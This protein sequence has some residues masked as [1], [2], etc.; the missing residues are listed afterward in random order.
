MEIDS[1]FIYFP[2]WVEFKLKFHHVERE[3]ERVSSFPTQQRNS[4]LIEA[5]PPL[6]FHLEPLPRG[7]DTMTKSRNMKDKGIS[8][9]EL[10]KWKKLSLIDRIDSTEQNENFSFISSALRDSGESCHQNNDGNYEDWLETTT[11]RWRVVEATL[12][13]SPTLP[14]TKLARRTSLDKLKANRARLW[15]LFTSPPYVSHFPCKAR[16]WR[17]GS[18]PRATSCFNPPKNTAT[19]ANVKDERNEIKVT[20]FISFVSS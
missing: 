9:G 6:P 13:P 14:P 12:I 3:I 11:R 17:V 19:T 5:F 1:S 16:R 18:A 2:G 8:F 10:K 4:Q 7:S 20:F 15:C